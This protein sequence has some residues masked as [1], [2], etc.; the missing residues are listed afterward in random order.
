VN[1]RSKVTPAVLIVFVPEVA[2]NVVTFELAGQVIPVDALK[3]PKIVIVPKVAAP[4]YPVGFTPSVKS[5]FLIELDEDVVKVP[6]PAVTLNEI[7][8][9]SVTDVGVIVL[10]VALLLVQ[11]I[12]G[13][14]VTDMVVAPVKIVPVL[15]SEIVFVPKARVP[16][17]PVHVRV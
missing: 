16:V 14:P 2:P 12:N 7:L 17:K 5:R 1:G 15:F 6:V 3:S 8:L 4:A 11:I 10:A 13:V 9:A